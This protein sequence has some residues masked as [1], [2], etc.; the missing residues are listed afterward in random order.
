MKTEHIHYRLDQEDLRQ[1]HKSTGDFRKRAA[2][3]HGAPVE[4]LH[5]TRMQKHVT[6]PAC[7]VALRR[8]THA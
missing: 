4:R 3:G 8:V 7:L 2:C 6:C 1:I 5:T